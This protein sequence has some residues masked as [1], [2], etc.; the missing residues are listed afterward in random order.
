M[1]DRNMFGK[2]E[3]IESLDDISGDIERPIR[4]YLIGGLAM[5]LRGSKAVTK[6]I[7]IVF[8]NEGSARVFIKALQQ[9]GYSEPRK[10]TKEYIKMNASYVFKNGKGQQF[11][12][13]VNQVCNGLFLSK[14]MIDRS[15]NAFE[16]G[17]INL[18]A[19]SLDDIFLFKGITERE[20]DIEDM[21][22]I[23]TS[24][25]NWEVIE[26][27]LRRQPESWK[28][29]Y[30]YHERLIDLKEKYH[31]ESPSIISL[32]ED[33]EISKA[34]C[35]IMSLL[36]IKP[37]TENDILEPVSREDSD[38]LKKVIRIM[39]DRKMISREG[40]RLLIT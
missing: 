11:D 14:R 16:S 24:V 19:L 18:R 35:I 13:F 25:I 17:N 8:K 33:A 29:L 2:V 4:G 27:E 22:S 38:F 36:K 15:I 37:R 1:A 32:E 34:M 28:W 21:Y 40:K 5:V 10:L 23:A 7:D 3:L 12:V 31:V 9:N 20:H 6:D 26:E 30:K 39:V